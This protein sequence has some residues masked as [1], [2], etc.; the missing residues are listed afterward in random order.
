MNRLSQFRLGEE[1]RQGIVL[2]QRDVKDLTEECE[3]SILGLV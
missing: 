2:L 1:E 3:R